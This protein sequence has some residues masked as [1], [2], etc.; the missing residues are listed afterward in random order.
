M[1]STA[2]SALRVTSTDGLITVTMNHPP[3]NL[4][5]STLIP[6]LKR[7]VREAAT[8]TSANVIIFESA[9]PD[10]FAAHVDVRYGSDPEAFMA[11]SKDDTGF[12]GL[13]PLQHLV[14]SV[15][16]LPQVTIAKLRGYLRGGGN[17]F[18]MAADLRYAAA[19]KTWMGQIESRLGII[20]GGGGTQLLARAV[21]RSRAL[22]AILT[23]D[24]YDTHT[25]ELYG[26]ITR[27][28]PDAELDQR[29]EEVA[30]RIASRMPTQIKAAKAAV[31][32][33]THGGRLYE[34]LQVEAAAL[35]HVYPSPPEIETYLEAAVEEG[36]QTPQNERNLEAFLDG[37]SK[38]P[39]RRATTTP[40]RT[41]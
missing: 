39:L 16:A 23:A 36:M 37:R 2:Y 8:D 19:D 9:V 5:D 14:A 32:P 4:L 3:L 10:F 24:V 15:R 29:V 35:A 26:W 13:L 30:K 11:L 27:A 28:F 17:E 6:E 1:S 12:K 22:E 41:D 33:T 20:P 38:S 31:D 18:A 7:F 21:G 40:K 25:A 34:D